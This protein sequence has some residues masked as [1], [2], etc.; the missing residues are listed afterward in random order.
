MK[1]KGN[2]S[3]PVLFNA[4]FLDV[5]FSGFRAALKPQN[6]HFLKSSLFKFSSGNFLGFLLLNLTKEIFRFLNEI[7]SLK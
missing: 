4:A 7:K 3:I 6:L 1:D 5:F 2:Y